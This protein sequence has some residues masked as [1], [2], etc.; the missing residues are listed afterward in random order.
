MEIMKLLKAIHA[1]GAT[2][3]LAT[4]DADLVDTVQM[5][6]IRLEEGKVIRDSFGG[7]EHAKS[8]NPRSRPTR[9]TESSKM[10]RG[11]L[12]DRRRRRLK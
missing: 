9:N 12:R 2:V 6:V 1:E 11:C 3:I 5:R 10:R 7:Y 8:T 4:H